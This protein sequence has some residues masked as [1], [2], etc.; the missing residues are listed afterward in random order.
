MDEFERVRNCS[1]RY[2][3]GAQ[4]EA[5][6]TGHGDNVGNSFRKGK[7]TSRWEAAYKPQAATSRPQG[8]STTADVSSPSTTTTVTSSLSPPVQPI[9]LTSPQK[10]GRTLSQVLSQDLAHTLSAVSDE[11]F[12][13]NA[14]NYAAS[15]TQSSPCKCMKPFTMQKGLQESLAMNFRITDR[16][17]TL[18]VPQMN[19]KVLEESFERLTTYSSLEPI[20]Y[21]P[22]K[23]RTALCLP[24]DTVYRDVRDMMIRSPLLGRISCG[25]L[26]LDKSDETSC[27]DEIDS[28]YDIESCS[29]HSFED[30]NDDYFEED[31]TATSYDDE[32]FSEDASFVSV[33]LPQSLGVRP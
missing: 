15:P 1:K 25:S 2:Q 4:Q 30:D 19:I 26:L 27:S 8:Q 20:F 33:V 9:R 24:A 16:I 22:V 32:S 11:S 21:S 14:M 17:S 18:S 7:T 5:R 29:E 3:R 12:R 6:A 28:L 13:N 10:K 23:I 31:F